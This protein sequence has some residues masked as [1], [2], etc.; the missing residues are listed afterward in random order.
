M[1]SVQIINC[2]HNCY[3]CCVLYIHISMV[4]ANTVHHGH[5]T[6]E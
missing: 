2:G 4:P 5:E 1:E 6:Y 3:I